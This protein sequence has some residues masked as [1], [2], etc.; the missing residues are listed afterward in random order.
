[1]VDRLLERVRC[2]QCGHSPLTFDGSDLR[3]QSCGFK[4]APTSLAPLVVRF[5]EDT[6]IRQSFAA[7]PTSRSRF[8]SRLR[9]WN[10]RRDAGFMARIPA[11]PESQL[12]AI[13]QAR[14]EHAL[15]GTAILDVGGGDGR[16]RRLLG[17]PADYTWLAIVRRPAG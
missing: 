7:P 1:M 5:S 15:N 2:P 4:A 8:R 6:G 13:K 9:D 10:Q 12:P 14:E 11:T 17:S 16:W 3:C